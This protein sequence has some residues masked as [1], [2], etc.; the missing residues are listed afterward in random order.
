VLR[1]RRVLRHHACR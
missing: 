1:A